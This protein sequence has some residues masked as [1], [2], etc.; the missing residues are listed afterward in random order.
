MKNIHSTD[1]IAE[2]IIRAFVQYGCSEMHMKTLLEKANAELEDG[3]IDVTNDE[4]LKAQIEKITMYKEE[5]DDLANLRRKTMLTLY[6]MYD[7]DKEMW[8]IVK[9]MGIGAMTMFEAYQASDDDPAL[10]QLALDANK[11]FVKALSLF[12]GTEVTE[13]AACFSDFLKAKGEE[14]AIS[15]RK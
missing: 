12:L 9:H 14:D 5:L 7:G 4:I 11:R 3:L 10:L 15:V 2:D 6:E 8:C 13:C 1:G